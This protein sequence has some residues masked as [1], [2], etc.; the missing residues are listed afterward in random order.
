M[1]HATVA[2]P[3]LRVAERRSAQSAQEF[4]VL[5]VPAIVMLTIIAFA[6]KLAKD[7]DVFWHIAAGQWMLDHGAVPHTDPFSYTFAGAAW[8]PQEWLSE[9]LMALIYRGGGWSGL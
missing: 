5:F 1:K 6:Q 4:F 3:D 8:N 9:I 2:S 7:G